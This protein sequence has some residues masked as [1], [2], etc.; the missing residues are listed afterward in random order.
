MENRKERAKIRRIETGLT[1][2]MDKERE[3]KKQRSSFDWT[4]KKK[5]ETP[6][7]NYKQKK[8][9]TRTPCL[10]LISFSLRFD[11]QMGLI[12]EELCKRT[13]AKRGLEKRGKDMNK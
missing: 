1:N 12:G 3:K 8:K 11:W 4:N 13:N 2:W 7:R 10:S 5:K 9:K 6:L